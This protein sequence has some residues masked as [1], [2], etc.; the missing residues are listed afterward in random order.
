MKS[1]R[2]IRIQIHEND[3]IK[4]IVIVDKLNNRLTSS[5]KMMEKSKQYEQKNVA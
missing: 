5:N 4:F 3:G 2:V 1:N